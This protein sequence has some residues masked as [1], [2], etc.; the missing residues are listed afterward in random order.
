MVYITNWQRCTHVPIGAGVCLLPF[1]M[2]TY[3]VAGIFQAA[4]PVKSLLFLGWAVAP[5][6]PQTV[7]E[8]DSVLISVYNYVI[9]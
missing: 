6:I 3:K 9:W 8:N 5:K 2:G 4:V 1:C 7:P